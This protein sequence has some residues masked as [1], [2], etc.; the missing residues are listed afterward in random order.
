MMDYLLLY[1]S[2]IISKSPALAGLLFL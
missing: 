2:K 1:Y